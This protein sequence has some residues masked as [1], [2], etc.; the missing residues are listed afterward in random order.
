MASPLPT[1]LTPQELYALACFQRHERRQ[2]WVGFLV[3]SRLN[4]PGESLGR[5]GAFARPEG[6][7]QEGDV[8][9]EPGWRYYF[10]GRGCCFTHENGTSIDVDFAD[11]GSA[12]EIDSYFYTNFLESLS[13]PEWCEAQLK[14]PAGFDCAWEFELARLTAL[15]LITREHRF[16][17]TENGRAL[18][19]S[20]APFIEAMNTADGWTRSWILCLFGDYS[21]AVEETALLSRTPPVRLTEAANLQR[22]KRYATLL[23]TLQQTDEQQAGFAIAALGWMGANYAYP[24]VRRQLL[25]RPISYL[26]HEALAVLDHWHGHEVNACLIEALQSIAQ[27]SLLIRLSS[28]FKTKPRD[29]DRPRLAL[30]VSLAES[31]LRRLDPDKM[32]TETGTLLKK[33]LQEDCYASDE[34][35]GFLLYLLSAEEGLAKLVRNLASRVP[36]CRTGAACFLALIADGLA[37]DALIRVA[38]GTIENGGHEAGCALSFMEDERAKKAA[39][40]WSRRN[41]GY[42]EAEG[43]VTEI[44]GEKRRVWSMAEIMRSNMRAQM[45]YYYEDFRERF[46]PLLTKWQAT[47]S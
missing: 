23:A 43:E 12:V 29:E 38:D 17:L 4:T 1:G 32:D 34:K 25:R 21:Y 26:H 22:E 11:D 40:N 37:L 46:Q 33:A 5:M 15:G 8:P 27:P 35:A 3:E 19:E 24:A 36:I 28:A 31:L 13:Q 7:P 6:I 14:R 30:I 47:R 10:H 16:R 20:I 9:D 44:F 18:A 42:E 45:L 39:Q 41:D 2:Q